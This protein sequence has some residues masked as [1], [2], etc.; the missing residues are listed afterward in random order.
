MQIRPFTEQDI[1][2]VCAIQLECQQAAQWKPED[3]LQLA[4]DPGSSILIAELDTS[5]P[6]QIAGFAAAQQIVD[7]TELRNIA[8]HPL[9]RRKGI[10]RALL[11]HLIRNLQESGAKELYLEVRPSN[12]AARAVYASKGFHLQYTRPG[13][14]QNP[15]EDALVMALEIPPP[16]QP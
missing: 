6:P 3:Y 5:H 1:D 12:Q 4:R 7:E 2:S 11:A 8:V 13:Y 16:S 10:A 9:H 14:Y 15:A